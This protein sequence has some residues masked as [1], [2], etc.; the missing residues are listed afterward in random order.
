MVRS[1]ETRA[2]A[3]R[4][5]S[6]ESGRD[7]RDRTACRFRT[8]LA[9]APP[10]RRLLRRVRTG[11]RRSHPVRGRLRTRRARTPLRTRAESTRGRDAMRRRPRPESPESKLQGKV[12]CT[13]QDGIDVVCTEGRQVLESLARVHGFGALDR[14]GIT[15]H[16]DGWRGLP[17]DAVFAS[18][19][20]DDAGRERRP[21][22]PR[23]S[24]AAPGA[25]AAADFA[26]RRPA[27]TADSPPNLEG[28]WPELRPSGAATL[29]ARLERY[30]ARNLNRLRPGGETYQ[31]RTRIQGGPLE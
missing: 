31:R 12:E 15:L 26:I 17:F 16:E 4:R 30:L 24:K 20:S 8:T 7:C 5:C 14:L 18:T 2:L 1:G 21:R 27:R 10:D 9:R 11:R 22:V 29:P 23:R 13:A 19:A 6:P 25:S 28:S 3:T